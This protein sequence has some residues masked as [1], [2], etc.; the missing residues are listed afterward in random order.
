MDMRLIAFIALLFAVSASAG[1]LLAN[2]GFEKVDGDTPARWHVFVK[3]MAGAYGRLDDR[4]PF[5]GR[6]CA[7][8]HV[9]EAYENEPYNNWSQNVLADLGGKQ[10]ALDARIRTDDATEAAIWV[11]CYRKK[12][13]A[14]LHLATTSTDSPMYGPRDWTPV[15]MGIHVPAGTDLVVCLD[16]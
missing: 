10:L 2:P 3:P 15:H 7:K 11:Q 14:L 1:E 5:E 16:R 8:L 13:F 6:L 9:P 12:P 4:K